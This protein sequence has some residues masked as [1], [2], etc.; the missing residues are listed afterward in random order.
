VSPILN[1]GALFTIQDED[2]TPLPPMGYI[3][4]GKI[5]K[6]SSFFKN[7]R[8]RTSIGIIHYF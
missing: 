2:V 6:N 5:E 1:S 7:A 4:I 8:N 3:I